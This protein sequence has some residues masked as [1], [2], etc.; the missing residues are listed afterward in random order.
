MKLARTPNESSPKYS[1][2]ISSKTRLILV[3]LFKIQPLKLEQPW[4]NFDVQE[5]MHSLLLPTDN[6][7][8]EWREFVRVNF[9]HAMS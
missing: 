2:P 6:S 7:E 9:L 8:R 1:P 5:S 4:T 3:Q